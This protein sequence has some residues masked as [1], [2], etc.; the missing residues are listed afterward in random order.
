MSLEKEVC[1]SFVAIA[2][3]PDTCEREVEG[4]F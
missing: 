4:W 3:R 1:D 2:A